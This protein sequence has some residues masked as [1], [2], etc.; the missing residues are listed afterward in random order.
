M[1]ITCSSI[2]SIL[3]YAPLF[4]LENYSRNA[5]YS[6]YFVERSISEEIRGPQAGASVG[7]GSWRKFIGNYVHLELRKIGF[8]RQ[9]TCHAN[10]TGAH[11]CHTH[12]FGDIQPGM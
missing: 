6:Q 1:D 11:Y 12:Y 2:H 8:H 7:G 10:H 9:R 3:T 4:Q 5:R